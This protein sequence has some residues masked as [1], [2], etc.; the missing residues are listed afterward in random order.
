MKIITLLNRK[1]LLAGLFMAVCTA[2]FAQSDIKTYTLSD[3]INSLF[4]D[5]IVQ[6]RYILM[7]SFLTGDNGKV[8]KNMRNIILFNIQ[9]G[10]EQWRTPID[11]KETEGLL[12][13]SEGL[14]HHMTYSTALL[15]Y[16]D[17]T[18]LWKKK[19]ELYNL[20]PKNKGFFIFPKTLN[21]KLEYCDLK[22]GARRWAT[23]QPQELWRNSRY[24]NDSTLCVS[25]VNYASQG[26]HLINLH[27]GAIKSYD[28]MA[29]EIIGRYRSNLIYEDQNFYMSDKQ[30]LFCLDNE[31]NELWKIELPKKSASASYIY[32]DSTNI[33]MVNFGM[34]NDYKLRGYPFIA[35]YSKQDG[36]QVFFT[37]MNEAKTPINNF[38]LMDNKMFM[39][40]DD[41]IVGSQLKENTAVQKIVWDAA[42]YGPLSNFVNSDLFIKTDSTHYSRI[43]SKENLLMKTKSLTLCVVDPIGMTV[44]NVYQPYQ[45]MGIVY[46]SKDKIIITDGK[47]LV[48]INAK[49]ERTRV[50]DHV[51]WPFLREGNHLYAVG[52]D[53][54]KLTDITL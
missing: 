24:V 17:G 34:G 3:S 11:M 23:N 32:S 7:T 40:F 43:S 26:L 51:L 27:N 49:G 12:F 52:N 9:T 10:E 5:S 33:Y 13:T 4:G 29:P 38:F 1:N 30:K 16:E 8:S 48:F 21:D 53:R 47:S 41:C 54:T 35:A 20:E 50:I 6:G 42:Q 44:S 15:S 19:G 22:T 14:I 18:A 39:I 31:L 45:Y 36:R 2:S 46:E 37:Q 25:F 28:A